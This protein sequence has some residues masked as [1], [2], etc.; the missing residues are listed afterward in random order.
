LK[1]MKATILTMLPKGL[2]S[3]CCHSL[4]RTCHLAN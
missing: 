4:R 2:N 1:F 3:I